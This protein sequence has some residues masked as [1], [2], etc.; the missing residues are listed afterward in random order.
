MLLTATD[1]LAR[2]YVHQMLFLEEWKN[3]GC[4]VELVEHPMSHDPHDQL[5]LQIRGAVAEYERTLIVERMRRGRLR[6]LRAGTMLP[7]SRPH[8]AIG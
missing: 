3:N 6:Q 7:W 8:M 1:R 4:Q 5:V 2:I